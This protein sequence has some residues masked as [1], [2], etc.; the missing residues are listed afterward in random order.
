MHTSLDWN[1]PLEPYK[2]LHPDR[3]LIPHLGQRKLLISE[4]DFLTQFNGLADTVV[5]AGAGPGSHIVVL[6][7]LFP[8]KMF[9]LWDPRPFDPSL[10]AINNISLNQDYFTDKVAEGLIKKKSF[11][12]LLF[13]SDIRTTS[14]DRHEFEKEVLHNL[15][16]Q[17]GWCEILKPQMASLKFRLPFDCTDKIPYYTGEIRL[18]P[19]VGID[20]AETRLW[21][22]CQTEKDYDCSAYEQ[23]MFHYNSSLRAG[24]YKVGQPE[25]MDYCNDCAIEWTVWQAYSRI[26]GAK[27]DPPACIDLYPQSFN[28]GPHG[29]LRDLP[30]KD[31]IQKLRPEIHNFYEKYIKN[32][33]NRDELNK[34]TYR[35]TT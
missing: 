17:R 10:E 4:I 9:Y 35:V 34:P 28:I 13:I 6:A 7:K 8:Q 31:R 29:K 14:H 26:S 21:T 32:E 5:Y 1:W 20:S 30:V 12:R 15:K 25:P 18:Q 11:K 24:N 16:Q 19:W 27:C 22:D 33:N 23:K 3:Y 2:I